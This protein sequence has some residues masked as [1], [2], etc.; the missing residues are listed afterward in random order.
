MEQVGGG[1]RKV[2]AHTTKDEARA[3]GKLEEQRLNEVA[4]SMA[5]GAV[6][7]WSEESE[8]REAER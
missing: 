5:K 4:D 3:Q 8:Q 6:R 1:V 7:R 2:K